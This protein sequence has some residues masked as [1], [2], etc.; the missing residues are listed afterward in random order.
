M[1]RRRPCIKHFVLEHAVLSP[2]GKVG[3]SR[4]FLCGQGIVS[5]CNILRKLAGDII[6][7]PPLGIHLKRV[8]EIEIYLVIGIALAYALIP[9]KFL[10]N[11]LCG[12]TVG[13]SLTLIKK[14]EFAAVFHHLIALYANALD[15]G[16]D[17][18][19]CAHGLRLIGFGSAAVRG[20]HVVAIYKEKTRSVVGVCGVEYVKTRILRAVIHD[21]EISVLVTHLGVLEIL[22]LLLGKLL[23]VRVG[24]GIAD[25]VTLR[26]S[27][28]QRN[29]I[30]VVI[31]GNGIGGF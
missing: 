27:L 10:V 31:V 12:V 30:A 24:K 2:F 4:L 6:P 8:G 26:K 21:L 18:L 15:K 19:G 9:A 25:I 3:K 14:R 23:A 5:V 7:V 13:N 17:I 29:R 16:V 11:A 1:L 28:G 20:G 22:A